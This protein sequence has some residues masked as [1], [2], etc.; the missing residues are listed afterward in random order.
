M[1]A[2]KRGMKK[3]NKDLARRD[4]EGQGDRIKKIKK[5]IILIFIEICTCV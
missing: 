1:D 4:Q 3:E 5:I 2:E